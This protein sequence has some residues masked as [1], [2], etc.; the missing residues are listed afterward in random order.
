MRFV[1][2][3]IV[4]PGFTTT[5]RLQHHANDLATNLESYHK[6]MMSVRQFKVSSLI[7][8]HV[9]FADSFLSH[10]LSLPGHGQIFR[11]RILDG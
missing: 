7:C 8:S 4:S 11:Q 2:A 9:V 6:Q 1:R 5:V 10:S 3:G